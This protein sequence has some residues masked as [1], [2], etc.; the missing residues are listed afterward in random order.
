[1]ECHNPAFCGNV[2]SSDKRLAVLFVQAV[3]YAIMESD[4]RNPDAGLRAVKVSMEVSP[5]AVAFNP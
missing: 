1:M 3:P 4:Q 5:V 2:N